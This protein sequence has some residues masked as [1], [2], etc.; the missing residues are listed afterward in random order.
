MNF[1]FFAG[2]SAVHGM[3]IAFHVLMTGLQQRGHRTTA[4]VNGW[5]NAE[6]PRLLRQSQ[7][8]YHEV[9]LG[10]IY[11]RRPRWTY[12]TLHAMPSA[13]RATR[14][15]VAAVRPDWLVFT[16]PQLLLWSAWILP[17]TKRVLYLHSKPERPSFALLGA[18][19]RR[20]TDRVVCVSDFIARCVTATPFGKANTS[21]VYNGI[22]MPVAPRAFSAQKPVRLGIVGAVARQK[23][24]RTLLRA[25]ARLKPRLPAGQFELHIIGR[26][27]LGRF[28]PSVDAEIAALG[29]GDVVRR[30]GYFQDR[31]ALYR[32]L[33]VVVAPAVDEGFGLTVVEAAAHGLPVVAARSG[34]L[35]EIVRHEQTGL[36]FE[37]GDVAGLA[38][39]LERLIVDDTLRREL[40]HAA[41]A[42]VADRFTAAQMTDDFLAALDPPR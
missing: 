29:I 22:D 9:D 39:A 19:A 36:L 38:A 1:L 3:E 10:R 23:Q 4:I 6:Y 26:E 30:P 37:P 18:L 5:N 14:A 40:G 11:L 7:L 24:H 12:H 15:I 33:D 28:Q 34:A 16:D 25:I 27:L 41:Q 42:W 31:D 21:V 32:G 20:H 13:I 8:A 2:G 17:P 35:P